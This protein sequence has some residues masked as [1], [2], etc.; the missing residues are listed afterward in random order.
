VSFPLIQNDPIDLVD[1]HTSTVIGECPNVWS[2]DDITNSPPL[3]DIGQEFEQEDCHLQPTNH[4]IQ[5]V[6]PSAPVSI[7][8][9]DWLDAIFNHLCDMVDEWPDVICPG[10]IPMVE[11]VFGNF[12]EDPTSWLKGGE[13]PFKAAV[14]N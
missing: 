10:E 12:M 11:D 8:L 5:V 6:L 3:H 2:V 1:V 9:D 4:Q 14:T 7:L 13:P